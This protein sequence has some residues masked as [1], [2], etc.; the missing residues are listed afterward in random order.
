VAIPWVTAL[1]VFKKVLPV[2]IDKAP[3][4]LQTLERRRSAAAPSESIKNE[5]SLTMVQE[6]LEALEQ[7]LTAQGEAITR[8]EATLRSTRRSLA[9]VWVALAAAVLGASIALAVLLRS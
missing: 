9:L 2:V 8:L 3:E 1:Y 6:R 5:S 4:L 7:L